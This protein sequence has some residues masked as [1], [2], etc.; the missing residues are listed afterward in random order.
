MNNFDLIIFDCDGTLV[1]TEGYNN[2]A[3]LDVLAEEGLH[4]DHHYAMTH[5]VGKTLTNILLSIQMETGKQ[6]PPDMRDRYVRRCVEL[7]KAGLLP[8]PGALELV[9][10]ASKKMKVCV[11]SNGERANVISALE[12]TGL[13][14]YFTE[15][16]TF[17][18]I[19]V[20]NPKPYPDLFLYAAEQM[21][22]VDPARCLVIEDSSSGVMAGAAAGM[23][24]W[25]FTGSSHEPEKAA[26][27][28]KGAG[29]HEVFSSL[30]H[31]RERLGI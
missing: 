21:G 19:Q 10:A 17:T 20:K 4:Y 6:F 2:Q 5:W 29:A 11:G 13:M 9:D 22:G 7:R 31:I 18:R 3:T 15:D 28:L 8:V 27:V 12:M 16:H 26:V 25:G 1:D 14:P 23:T 24:V 30:I